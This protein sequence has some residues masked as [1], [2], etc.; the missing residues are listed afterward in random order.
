M[1]AAIPGIPQSV[2]ADIIASTPDS[3]DCAILLHWMPPSIAKSSVQHYVVDSPAGRFITRDTTVEITLLIHHCNNN[4]Y[5]RI[6]AVDYCDRDGPST[7]DV[8]GL[9]LVNTTL[10]P[11]TASRNATD[12]TQSPGM[13]I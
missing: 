6:H 2:T 4:T 13:I 7:N 12:S 3:E 8:L 1:F 9:L 11:V 10:P 5:I